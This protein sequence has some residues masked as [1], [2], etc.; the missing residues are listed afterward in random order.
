M[1]DYDPFAEILGE[2]SKEEDDPFA[3]ILKEKASF[4]E[5]MRARMGEVLGTTAQGAGFALGG[6]GALIE[7]PLT[8]DTKYSGALSEAGM[9]KKEELA[10]RT[11][12]PEGKEEGFGQWLGSTAVTL[13]AQIGAMAVSPSDTMAEALKAGEQSDM[14]WSMGMT[15]AI[16]NYVGLRAPAAFGKKLLTKVATGAASNAA[17]DVATR[18]AISGMAETDKMEEM[19]APTLKSTAGA[20]ILGGGFGALHSTA[21]KEVPS[22]KEEDAPIPT[23]DEGQHV[24]L[25]TKEIVTQRKDEF[26]KQVD[27]AEYKIKQLEQDLQ[28]PRNV[29]RTPEEA[30]QYKSAVIEQI[31]G[32]QKDITAL[33]QSIDNADAI[34]EGRQPA[35]RPEGTSELPSSLPPRPDDVEFVRPEEAGVPP[36]Q[37][38][39]RDLFDQ[40]EVSPPMPPEVPLDPSRID[41]EALR[42]ELGTEVP[43]VLEGDRTLDDFPADWNNIEITAPHDTGT[44]ADIEAAIPAARPKGLVING[45]SDR[46]RSIVTDWVKRLGLDK[47]D[48][49]FNI[50]HGNRALAGHEVGN[51]TVRPDSSVEINVK[52]AEDIQR[53]IEN[54]PEFGQELKKL[55]PKNAAELK[56]VL[57]AA[58]E[59]GHILLAKLLQ[60]DLFINGKKGVLNTLDGNLGIKKLLDDYTKWKETKSLDEQ[61]AAGNLLAKPQSS[62]DYYLDFP[63]FFAPG[64]LVRSLWCD[65]RVPPRTTY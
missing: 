25:G 7:Q 42:E 17:Q 5:S 35:P 8:G 63:E 46:I 9:R 61:R 10:K 1:S 57:T 19:Y 23:V 44:I 52:T 48:I 65:P 55:T 31:V 28:D 64:T 18:S 43:P 38:V 40:E 36:E 37:S 14:A 15:D 59:L 34:L 4:S 51:A 39:Q 56:E 30:E 2:T 54:H 20:A 16:G 6:L 58:H 53:S 49:D 21:G 11:A 26:E 13:P 62:A 45:G 24:D 60:N 50:G 27:Y 29:K 47:E 41:V 33:K 3:T 12:L 32:H 22:P